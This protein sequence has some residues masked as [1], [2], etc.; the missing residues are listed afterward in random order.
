[1]STE[2]DILNILETTL[3]G[4][5]VSNGY[6]TDAGSSVFKNLEYET[7]PENDLWPCSIY[8]P[9]EL[10]SGTDGDTPPELGEQNNFLP[11]QLE[12]YVVDDERGTA[13]QQLKEDWRKA[14]TAAGYFNG[15]A[16]RVQDYK[17]SAEVRPG[18]EGYWSYVS[19]SFTIFF[20]TTW[21]EM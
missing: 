14:I 1:M 3:R 11:I 12:G 18:A 2:L 5:T 21:G 7:A 4:V 6:Q 19:A 17:T 9:G 8:F 15:L 16:E 20:V 13:G 10:T